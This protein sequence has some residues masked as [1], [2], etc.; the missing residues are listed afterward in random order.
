MIPPGGKR[1]YPDEHG[2]EADMGRG[3]YDPKIFSD[4]TF[5]TLRRYNNRH[6]SLLVSHFTAACYTVMTPKGELI[7]IMKQVDLDAPN[8]KPNPFCP[9]QTPLQ[10]EGSHNGRLVV[11][12]HKKQCDQYMDDLALQVSNAAMASSDLPNALTKFIRNVE[13]RVFADMQSAPPKELNEG[14]GLSKEGRPDKET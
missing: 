10:L 9:K 3:L 14:Y 7:E 12:R 11:D 5:D 8:L 4:V 6:A 13:A 1:K 2:Y